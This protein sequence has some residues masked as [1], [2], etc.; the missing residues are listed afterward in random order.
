MNNRTMIILGAILILVSLI[1]LISRE[2]VVD[3]I[4]SKA[5]QFYNAAIGGNKSALDQVFGGGRSIFNPDRRLMEE[6]KRI[7]K[8]AE[9][10][11]KLMNYG[12]YALGAIG[13][14]LLLAGLIKQNPNK[15]SSE[16]SDN[17][18]KESLFCPDCGVK[19]EAKVKFC[20]E[21][22]HEF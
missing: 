18:S 16:E 15:T 12:S 1:M 13:L 22:G 20:P 2:S 7:H 17:E 10:V 5:S 4:H 11:D 3:S 14:V 8:E 21:C 6:S 9:T 19:L